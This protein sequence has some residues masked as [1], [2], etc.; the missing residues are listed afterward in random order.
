MLPESDPTPLNSLLYSCGY[1]MTKSDAITDFDVKFVTAQCFSFFIAGFESCSNLL[2]FILYELAV[3]P[4][5]QKKLQEEV[6][7]VLQ[8]HGGRITYD[9]LQEM[10]YMDKVVNGMHV[11]I[12]VVTSLLGGL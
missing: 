9:S 4:N 12:F 1:V 10:H 8:K 6:D 3:H 2:S 7:T 5:V 11:L